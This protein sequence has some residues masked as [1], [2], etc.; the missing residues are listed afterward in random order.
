M[1]FRKQGGYFILV[2]RRLAQRI[3]GAIWLLDGF[4]QLKP[5]MFTQAFVTGVILPSAQGQPRW[6]AGLV[7]FAARLVSGHM[8]EWDILFALVQLALGILLLSDRWVRPTLVASI[9]WALIVWIAEGIGMPFGAQM[10]LLNGAPGAG[11]VYAMVSLAVWPAST[12]PSAW[13]PWRQRFAQFALGAIWLWGFVLQL[14]L[15]AASPSAVPAQASVPHL[16]GMQMPGTTGQSTYLSLPLSVPQLSRLLAPIG[17][18]VAIG[19]AMAVLLLGVLWING[20]SLGPIAWFSLML[21]ALFWWL[22]QSFGGMWTALGTDPNTAP[23]MALL[24]LCATPRAKLERR[25]PSRG[26]TPLG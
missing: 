19:L 26:F 10:T 4:L 8:A 6:I 22:G 12:D 7:D 2:S 9:T 21:L 17:E 15:I 20:Q 13:L 16:S 3:L 5:A 18:P 24:V 23:L 11:V 14:E 25:H 1:L